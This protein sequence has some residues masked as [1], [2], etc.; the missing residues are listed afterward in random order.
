MITV[1]YTTSKKL[2]N[3]LEYQST[4]ESKCLLLKD[5]QDLEFTTKWQLVKLLEENND[6]DIF[7]TKQV[8]FSNDVNAVHDI[9]E[10]L[11][12]TQKVVTYINHQHLE[13]SRINQI[14]KQFQDK[15]KWFDIKGFINDNIQTINALTQFQINRA[16]EKNAK[17]LPM[18]TIENILSKDRSRNLVFIRHTIQYLLSNCGGSSIMVGK[19][20]GKDHSTILYAKESYENYLQYY[21]TL[22]EFHLLN[23]L[24]NDMENKLGIEHKKPIH[25]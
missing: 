21:A 20:M 4:F 12:Y 11:H 7:V 24:K 15:I 10:A 16:D 9:L 3:F 25:K 22:K 19:A 2:S 13:N 5:F 23:E 18:H 8:D 1:Y 14:N 6:I 17:I